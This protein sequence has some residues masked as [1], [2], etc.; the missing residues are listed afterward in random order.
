MGRASRRRAE[1]R[2]GKHEEKRPHRKIQEAE[3]RGRRVAPT[4]AAY[5]AA[6]TRGQQFVAEALIARHNRRMEALD[7]TNKVSYEHLRSALAQILSFDVALR[8][9]GADQERYPPDYGRTWVDHLAWGVDSVI[10]IARLLY[11]GQTVGAALIARTQLERW[12]GNLAYNA[13]IDQREKESTAVFIGRVWAAE[14]ALAERHLDKDQDKTLDSEM[15]SP[16]EA[17]IYGKD[18]QKYR[19]P[20]RPTKDPEYLYAAIS[21]L[22]HARD[23]LVPSALWDANGLLDPCGDPPNGVQEA[24]DA[25]ADVVSLVLRR[26]ARCIETLAIQTKKPEIAVFIRSLGD[27]LPA[28]DQRAPHWSLWPLMLGRDQRT[29]EQLVMQAARDYSRVFAGKRPLGRLYYDDEMTDLAFVA[30]R[31]KSLSLS[32]FSLEEER[33]AFGGTLNFEPLYA[34]ESGIVLSTEI[35][36]LISVWEV[37]DGLDKGALAVASS[38]L[39]TAFWLW[40][41]DDDRAMA[42]L[43]VVL[44]QIA[45]ARVWRE[46]PSTAEKLENSPKTTPRDWLEAAGWKR[47][48]ALNRAVGELAHTKIGSRWIA[49]RNL[50]IDLQPGN[51]KGEYFQ[52]TGRGRALEAV[53]MLFGR[54]LVACVRCKSPLLADTFAELLG[55]TGEDGRE[56]EAAIEEW[57]DHVWSRREAPLGDGGFTGPAV[58]RAKRLKESR[59]SD[60]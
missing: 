47:L 25:I 56:R 4:L 30:H 36:G 3:R 10:A 39:R 13:A 8:D 52:N 22:L 50:I 40:L 37:V 7:R 14:K 12:T 44:E 42:M 54:E 45:R 23:R 18:E 57:L 28:G 32:L 34:R 53:T 19:V 41:E 51:E 21:E 24:Q 1:K 59:Q 46:K 35:A 27:E 26:I 48:R 29:M 17:E 33:K 31:A 11:S 49:A 16:Q 20:E 9:L 5:E 55:F 43:R 2:A 58:E 15:E 6:A 38:A 60:Q